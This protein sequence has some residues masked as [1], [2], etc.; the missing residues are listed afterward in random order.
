MIDLHLLGV[1]GS[2]PAVGPEFQRYGGNTSCIAVAVDHAP[3]RLVLDAGTGLRSLG[4]LLPDGVFNGTILLSHLHW[5]HTHGLPFAPVVDRDDAHV[6]LLIPDQGVAAEEL[7]T[8]WLVDL[9]IPR[10]GL[11]PDRGRRRPG[12]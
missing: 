12:A 1:R 8:E 6:A 10:R 5:D 11:A 3:P 7:P 9:R 2:T 4:R